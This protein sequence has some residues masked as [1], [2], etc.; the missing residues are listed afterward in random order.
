[1]SVPSPSRTPQRRTFTYADMRSWPDDER[2]EL[3]EG[4]AFAM[5]GP[6]WQHQGVSMNLGVQLKAHFGG[7]GCRVFAAPFDVRLPERDEHD[8]EIETVVQPDLVVVCD[9]TKL[10]QRGCRGAPELVVEILSP[11]TA[12][13]D[14]VTKRALYDRHGVREYWLVHPLDRIL[15]VYRR[16][17]SGRFEA[18]EPVVAA[19]KLASAGFEGLE[20]DW[21]LVFA[22]VGETP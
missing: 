16:G 7:Q 22:D 10:D 2:W 20:I 4:E 6:S 14:H 8:D 15:M 9:K 13:R 21:D 17:E 11:S 19:G 18:A 5:T 12:A 3:V 1:M